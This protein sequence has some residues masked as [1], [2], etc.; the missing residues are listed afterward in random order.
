VLGAVV[1][2]AVV[3]AVLPAIV[4]GERR[5]VAAARDGA[6][7]AFVTL[8]SGIT[9]YERGGAGGD[10]A[11]ALVL[12]HGASGPMS[13]WDK[14]FSA[15]VAAGHPVLRYDLLGRG[16]SDR[17][18]GP[19]DLTLY[20]TQLEQLLDATGLGT[21][22]LTLVG[23]SMGAI[24]ATEFARRH[25]GRI[26]RIALIGPAGF[27]IEANPLARLLAVPGVGDY[28]MRVIGDRL[29]PAHHAK[30]FVHPEAFPEAL[31]AYRAQ[32]AFDGYKHAIVSTMRD[33]PM[34]DYH[35][36]YAHLVPLGKPV[37]LLWGKE[38]RTFPA[39]NFE[40]TKN[41]LAPVLSEAALLDNAAHAP[42]YEAPE[43]VNRALL[44]FVGG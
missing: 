3:L 36:G 30:Y 14:T 6:S 21:T 16:L 7:G 39:S 11:H 19:Y 22:K 44:A 2:F 28:L 1:A 26:A 40:P 8:A 33:M 25:P 24:V 15:L 27:A 29:L 41:L 17:P 32:L 42:Q 23:S 5:P 13:I 4:D 12:I 20:V 9:H 31:D 43:A 34:N 37:L 10:A 35:D 18:R 38:D